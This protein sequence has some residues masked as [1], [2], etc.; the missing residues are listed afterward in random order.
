MK[1]TKNIH[2]EDIFQN[3]IKAVG[4]YAVRPTVKAVVVDSKNNIAL[5]KT[6]GHYLLPGGGVE[7]NE[8][9][10]DAIKREIMEEL[11]CTIEDVNEFAISHQFRNKSMKH[12]EIFFFEARVLGVKGIP[13]TMQEDEKNKLEIFWYN[14]ETVFNLLKSQADTV[15]ENEYAFCFNARSHYDL[16]EEYYKSKVV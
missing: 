4:E 5:L 7:N 3:P 14:K 16:F 9:K 15:D 13:T 2:D 1:L 6:R 8:D 11:G 12:Y 10:I